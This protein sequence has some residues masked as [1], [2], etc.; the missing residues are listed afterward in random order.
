[1]YFGADYGHGSSV[2][3]LNVS[4]DTFVLDIFGSILITDL[5]NHYVQLRSV[6][7]IFKSYGV[8]QERPES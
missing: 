2:D 1:M 4:Q 5:D 8:T 3:C 6:I 7:V